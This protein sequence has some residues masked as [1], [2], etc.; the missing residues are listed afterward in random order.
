MISFLTYFGAV[1]L[2]AFCL[3]VV[4]FGILYLL[5]LANAS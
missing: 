3:G 2:G 1:A 5:A 4:F